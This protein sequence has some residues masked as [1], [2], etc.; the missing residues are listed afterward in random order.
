MTRERLL[1]DTCRL[2]EQLQGALESRVLIEEANGMIAAYT[3][4]TV[5]DAFLLLRRY[6]R[7]TNRQLRSVASDLVNRQIDPLAVVRSRDR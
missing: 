7:N 5:D 1:Q 3:G 6:A 4:A 2:A